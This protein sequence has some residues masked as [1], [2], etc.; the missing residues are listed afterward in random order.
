VNSSRAAGVAVAALV[1]FGFQAYRTHRVFNDTA[2]EEFHIACGLEVWQRGQYTLEMQH[3]R[4]ARVLLALPAHLAGLRLAHLTALWDRPDPQ[5]YWRTLGAARL[6]NLVWAPVLIV[7][8]YLWARK[9]QG[10]AAGL[11]AAVLVSF[12]PNLLAHA[13]VAALD[14]GAATSLFVAAYHLR[15]WATQPTM[16]RCV[17][18]GLACGIA[19]LTKFSA[20]VFLP[21]IVASYLILARSAG[22]RRAILRQGPVFVVAAV[23][24]VWAG[25]LF[26]LGPL[27]PR[28]FRSRSG[29]STET[30]VHAMEV[31]SLHRHYLPAPALWRGLMDV[32][33]HHSVGH[34]AYLLGSSHQFGWWYYF[35]VAL[36]VKTT[37]PLLLLLI[38]WLGVRH[39]EGRGVS[40]SGS[41]G[42]AGGVDGQQS[43]H[44]GSA[45][46][47]G[48]SSDRRVGLR[49][50][51]W[52]GCHSARGAP[53]HRGS[54]RGP[55]PLARR[56]SGGG[57][58]RLPRLL[59][60]VR[61]GREENFLLDSN[62]DWGQ[63]LERL[64]QFLEE[65]RITEFRLNYSGR[66][67][68]P[69]F[70]IHGARM[71]HA[72]ERPSGGGSRQE[73]SGVA[74]R[75]GVVEI[76]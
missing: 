16:W 43:R 12:S 34:A 41:R 49:G 69:R 53:R 4:L 59:Q 70:R 24:V 50:F 58:P 22:G 76:L 62:L 56:R 13:S 30:V 54:R 10:R 3:P 32:A 45:C 18:A 21:V 63:D 29:S 55:H 74:R 11:G 67:E 7:Y 75:V 23:L 60:P 40:D 39:G 2:D 52:S 38:L 65:R 47:G 44:W 1:L 51:H 17:W 35:P 26:T 31:W 33:G 57:P 28:H 9:L 66:V 15:R 20:L 36:A 27:P 14:F 46:S 71:L 19:V 48:V 25:Y 61:A 73:F 72:G 68:E 37:L 6:G 64:R 5:F 42:R 8:T